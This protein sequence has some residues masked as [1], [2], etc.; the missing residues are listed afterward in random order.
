MESE[1]RMAEKSSRRKPFEDKIPEEVH[2]HVR[3]AR[4]EVRES[5]K[6]FLPPEFIENRTKARK[7][8]LLAWRSIIDAALEKM[9]EK[10]V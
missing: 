7:E 6:A 4:E 1:V 5:I 9:E 8:M 2:Q 3:A 10:K